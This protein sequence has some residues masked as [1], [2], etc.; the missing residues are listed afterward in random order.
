MK[1]VGPESSVFSLFELPCLFC[2]KVIVLCIRNSPTKFKNCSFFSGIIGTTDLQKLLA[3][4]FLASSP[5]S[6]C[7][8]LSISIKQSFQKDVLCSC[9]HL[10]TRSQMSLLTAPSQ[11]P[12]IDQTA[13]S[14]L[15]S[16]KILVLLIIVYILL[17]VMFIL[18]L[19]KYI[20]S[21]YYPLGQTYFCF[22]EVIVIVM[23][24]SQVL[25]TTFL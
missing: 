3:Y 20:F 16:D 19:F 17:L 14:T 10:Q 6:I 2:K 18:M 8:W 11:F 1:G 4:L 23:Q 21:C 12:Y 9:L 15:H 5:T 25:C 13:I 22:P 24:L 7:H